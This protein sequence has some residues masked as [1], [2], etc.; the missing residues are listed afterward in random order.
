MVKKKTKVLTSWKSISDS[1][2]QTLF[3]AEP[4]TA[5]NTSAFAGYILSIALFFIFLLLQCQS[6]LTDHLLVCLCI[7]QFQRFPSPPGNRGAFAH[8]VSRGSGV[9]ANFIAART[10]GIS[11]PLGNPRAYLTQVFSKDG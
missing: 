6:N 2:S 9:L 4:V 10:L 1:S 8:V 7:N 11:I 3:S 5:G